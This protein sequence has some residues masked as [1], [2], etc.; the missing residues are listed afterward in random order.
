MKIEGANIKAIIFDMDGVLIDSEPLWKIAEVEGFSKVGLTLTKK[1]CEATVGVRIDEVVKIWYDKVGWTGPGVLEVSDD[2]VDILIREIKQHG[3][4]LTGVNEALQ[5]LKEQDFMIGLATSSSTR[6]IDEV[7]AR[8]N[9]GHYF[10]ATHSAENEQFGK[11]HP[12][13]YLNCASKLGVPA[14][15]CLAIEDSFNGVMSAKAA[16]M[17]V[18]AIP[19]KSHAHDVRL[20][21]IADCVL[22]DL[23]EL[24]SD[25]IRK[26]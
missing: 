24:T 8:L 22:N 14:S 19:E 26:L 18:I 3:V 4:A 11:P 20:E 15:D 25:L 13:V 2:I 12:A 21:E 10:A 7:L 6:I 1:D 16:G 17:K 23:T 5:M 9:I